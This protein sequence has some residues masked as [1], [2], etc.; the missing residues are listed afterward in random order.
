MSEINSIYF[1]QKAKASKEW[2]RSIVVANEYK[3]SITSMMHSISNLAQLSQQAA[4]SIADLMQH[5]A[6]MQPK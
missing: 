4:A 1:E 5:H 3:Y 6:K 2:I